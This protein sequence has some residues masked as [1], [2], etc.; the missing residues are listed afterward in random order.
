MYGRAPERSDKVP[1]GCIASPLVMSLRLKKSSNLFITIPVTI[2]LM[3]T[4][5]PISN[6]TVKHQAAEDSTLV[7]VW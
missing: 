6:T 7:T 5:V 4:P 2:R 3:E 1:L